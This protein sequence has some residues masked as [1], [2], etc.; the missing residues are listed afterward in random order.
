MAGR[1]AVLLVH[2]AWHGSWCWE[3]LK[4]L[5]TKDG[6]RVETVDLPSV[7]SG[8]HGLH[9][10][11]RVVREAMGAIGGP[12]VVVAHSYGGEPA[13][14]G[15]AGHPAVQR[16]IYVAAFLLDVGES[17][18][19]AIGGTPPPWWDVDGDVIRPLTPEAVFFN[20]IDDPTDA[21]RRLE[22]QSYRAVTDELTAAAW[23]STESTYV[24]CENDQAIPVFAQEAMAQRAGK[25]E[26]LASGH[27]PFLSCPEELAAIITKSIG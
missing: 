20:D 8:R 27:S 18:L 2:G 19:G 10:D 9:D 6:W 7:G 24:V 15:S 5:L 23:R 4:E 13:T 1:P 22:P 3:P 16:L 14:E 17:L 25:V 12:V 26:R 21:V 11:A